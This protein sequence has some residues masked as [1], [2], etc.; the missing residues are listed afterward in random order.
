M[1][2]DPRNVLGTNVS[3]NNLLTISCVPS[4]SI[5]VFCVLH[6]GKV[7]KDVDFDQ[8]LSPLSFVLFLNINEALTLRKFDSPAN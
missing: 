5:L 8:K 4:L 7:F 2:H 1:W 6:K 3:L